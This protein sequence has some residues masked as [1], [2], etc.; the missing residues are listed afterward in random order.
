M[1]KFNEYSKFSLSEVNRE[2]LQKCEGTNF[3]EA[4]RKAVMKCVYTNLKLE[5][6]IRKVMDPFFEVST[7]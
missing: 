6:E 7:R 3:E 1:K 2:V 5:R 4:M